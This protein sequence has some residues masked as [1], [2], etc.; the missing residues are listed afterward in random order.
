MAP[1]PEHAFI[2][3][4]P[5]RLIQLSD[6]IIKTEALAGTRPRGKT[7]EED[8]LLELELLHS[9]KENMEHQIVVEA[10]CQSLLPFVETID[11]A[12]EPS[13]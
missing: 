2:G 13:I 4:S 11:K 7:Q 9:K 6:G 12:P 1:H 5:E 8:R 3:R 10:I